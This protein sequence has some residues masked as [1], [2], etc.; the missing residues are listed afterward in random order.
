MT[1][2]LRVATLNLLYYP[3]GGR[4]PERRA[5]VEDEL[6][7]VA[8]DLVG[9]Q[10][11]DRLIDQDRALTMAVAERGYVAVRAAEVV[12]PRYPRHWDGVVSLV[13]STAGELVDHVVRRLTYLRVV[14][15][16]RL[17]RPS[18][19][20]LRWVNTHLHH[21]DGPPGYVARRNQ[22]VSILEWLATLPRVDAE[23]LV[24]DLNATPDEPAI[25]ELRRGG[26]VSAVEVT[27]G[28]HE[29]TYPSGLVAPSIPRGPAMC[30]DY[31][32]TRGAVRVLDARLAWAAP[33]PWDPTLY[34]SDHRGVVA[35]VA[36]D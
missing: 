20:T 1:E 29:P 14:Q 31:V 7:A 21:P 6:R 26:F 13:T 12:R 32:W 23:V 36:L 19:T 24:G 35:D 10:E 5:L 27:L 33:A 30:L 28:R 25:A 15:A 2:P 8:P 3:Q 9:L 11:V 17:R 18:G 16:I 34:P 4:W 22:V